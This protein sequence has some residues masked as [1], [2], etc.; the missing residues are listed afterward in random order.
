MSRNGTLLPLTGDLA[1]EVDRAVEAWHEGW[2]EPYRW[3][4][5]IW[6]RDVEHAIKR[7]YPQASSADL[8]LTARHAA[9]FPLRDGPNVP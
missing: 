4:R 7:A 6:L 8:R 5:S 3:P 2:Y 9:P 1:D